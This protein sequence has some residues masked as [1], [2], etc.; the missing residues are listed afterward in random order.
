M[1]P[2][3]LWHGSTSNPTT[4]ARLIPGLS[5]GDDTMKSSYNAINANRKTALDNQWSQ[6][7]SEV[8]RIAS[9]L[10]RQGMTRTDALKAAER[11]V[12]Q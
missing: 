3:N 11:M 2:K 12:S 10:Q 1:R 9:Q 4:P 7:I 8:A 5:F 6:R